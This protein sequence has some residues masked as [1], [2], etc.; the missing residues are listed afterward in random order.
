MESCILFS[1]TYPFVGRLEDGWC[2]YKPVRCKQLA[3]LF[4][5][6]CKYHRPCSSKAELLQQ[7]CVTAGQVGMCAMQVLL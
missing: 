6:A 4:S 5:P 7:Q 3:Q 2:A 1:S